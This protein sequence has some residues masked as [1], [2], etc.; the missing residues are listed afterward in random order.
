MNKKFT[1]ETCSDLDYNEI[2]AIVSYEEETV[3]IISQEEGIENAKIEL[4]S[5][6]SDGSKNYDLNEFIFI[7]NKAKEVLKKFL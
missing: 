4:F 6:C 2:I 1:I 7:I 5:N 3:A